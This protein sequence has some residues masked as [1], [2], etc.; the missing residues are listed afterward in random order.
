[1]VIMPVFAEETTE[2]LS[3]WVQRYEVSTSLRAV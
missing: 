1:M 3:L 2:M